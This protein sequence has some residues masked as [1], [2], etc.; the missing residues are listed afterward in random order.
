MWENARN[1]RV[2][3]VLKFRKKKKKHC[4]HTLSQVVGL[5]LPATRV[6]FLL[7]GFRANA[8]GTRCGREAAAIEEPTETKR[9]EER[10]NKEMRIF[11]LSFMRRQDRSLIRRQAFSRSTPAKSLD[12]RRR[13][14]RVIRNRCLFYE[15]F[16]LAAQPAFQYFARLSPA[17]FTTFPFELSFSILAVIPSRFITSARSFPY[18]RVPLRLSSREWYILFKPA[19]LNQ[20]CTFPRG[21]CKL[22]R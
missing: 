22:L 11:R 2:C 8:R 6:L 20:R 9:R 12:S 13:G 15:T 18:G 21:V 1:A 17:S 4:V 3:H 19:V 16:Y 5:R 14:R 7:P 10:C